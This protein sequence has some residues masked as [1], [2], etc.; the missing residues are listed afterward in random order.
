MGNREP[1]KEDRNKAKAVNFGF[2]Y[3]MGAGGFV[4][5]A[6]DSYGQIFNK[7]EAE[8]YRNLFFQKYAGLTEWHRSMEHVCEALGGVENRFGRFRKLPKIYA[9][10]KWEKGEA[11]RRA[12]NT[13]VQGTGSDLLLFA[14]VEVADKIKKYGAFVVGTVHDS[15]LVDCPL[16]YSEDVCKIIKETMEHPTA[17]DD[18]KVSFKIPLVADVACGAWG[19]K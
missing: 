17:M 12:I 9:Q 6:F 10:T 11:I 18:F 8:Q 5:Y 16:D 4:N 15:M 3:G 2:L 7:N 1:S 14:M 19:S 13:P